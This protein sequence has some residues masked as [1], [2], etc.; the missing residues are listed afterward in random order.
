L[1]RVP[2]CPAFN[3]SYSDCCGLCEDEMVIPRMGWR[4][5]T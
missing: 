1:L 5:L 2:C 4:N 3:Q